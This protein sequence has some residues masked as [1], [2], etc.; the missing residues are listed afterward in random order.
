MKR[1]IELQAQE[2]LSEHVLVRDR[3]D[4]ALTRAVGPQESQ[5][6]QKTGYGPS[7]QKRHWRPARRK[8]QHGTGSAL[9]TVLYPAPSVASVPPW[10]IPAAPPASSGS[11]SWSRPLPIPS[12]AA[13]AALGGSPKKK[14][15]LTTTAPRVP[16]TPCAPTT[17]TSLP[18]SSMQTLT[19]DQLVP[20]KVAPSRASCSNADGRIVFHFHM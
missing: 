5:R 2:T 14:P 17:A 8:S 19:L 20:Q 15:T 6:E 18:Q 12:T 9:G 16:T 13:A 11:T 1:D 3:A 4:L 7:R 10:R